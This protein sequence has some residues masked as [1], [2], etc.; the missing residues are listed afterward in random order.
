MVKS[1]LS[2]IEIGCSF[3]SPCNSISDQNT[4]SWQIPKCS[5]SHYN[6]MH[7][8]KSKTISV[9]VIKQ[10]N[11]WAT[12]IPLVPG[13]QTRCIRE[14]LKIIPQTCA[15]LSSKKSK[16]DYITYPGSFL[17]HR[18][19]LLCFFLPQV[20]QV[21]SWKLFKSDYCQTSSI[22]GQLTSLLFNSHWRIGS[23]CCSVLPSN[24][25]LKKT[26]QLQFHTQFP[27]AIIFKKV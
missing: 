25:F 18:P 19:C 4:D 14:S 24:F 21:P 20:S 15:S 22:S 6:V 8:F 27:I 2:G 5:T 17:F 16:R 1:Q 23:I 13:T 10:V 26:T 12:K 11:A 9:A 3:S 7:T